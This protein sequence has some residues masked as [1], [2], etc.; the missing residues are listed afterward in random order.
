MG[1]LPWPARGSRVFP[2]GRAHL[3]ALAGAGVVAI[4][5][6]ASTAWPRLVGFLLHRG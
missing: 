3:D 2:V 1:G 5:A 6:C 4:D